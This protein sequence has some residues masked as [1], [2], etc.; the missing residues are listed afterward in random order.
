MPYDP[1]KHHRR[2][3]RLKDYDY[4]QPGGYFVTICTQNRAYLFGELSN[5]EMRLNKAGQMVNDTWHSLPNR[6][7]S[8][9]LDAYI[10]MPN[11]V[12]GI[13][14]ITDE[15]QSVV[16]ATTR[17]A[18]DRAGTRPAPT[19]GNI[20]RSSLGQIIGAFKSM[21]THQYALG[22]REYRWAPFNRRLW[23]R[24]YYESIIRDER[25]INAIRT[26]IQANPYNW[27]DDPDNPK[28]LQP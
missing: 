22:V 21:T 27:V 24:N 28:N 8:V 2:S 11:H 4:T 6:F 20:I 15:K 13:I 12:H 14:L 19:E 25:A 7:L 1:F 10:I 3:I 17:V 26:Y 23:Q 16:G 18:Q 9:Q 5:C